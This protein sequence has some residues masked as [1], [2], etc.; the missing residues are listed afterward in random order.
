MANEMRRNAQPAAKFQPAP[1]RAARPSWVSNI[2]WTWL[3]WL[4]GFFI[5]PAAIRIITHFPVT[6]VISGY[7]G[8][9]DLGGQTQIFANRMLAFADF[10]GR[11]TI[12]IIMLVALLFILLYLI[13][14]K[15]ID[16]RKWGLS[17]ANILPGIVLFGLIWVSVYFL[18][19]PFASAF[20]GANFYLGIPMPP[21]TE[22]PIPY[23]TV[24][25]FGETLQ[26]MFMPKLAPM[27]AIGTKLTSPFET[28]IGL[29]LMD[30]IR[31]WFL[32]APVLLSMT[33]G[34]F[35]NSFKEKL[36]V[37]T[38]TSNWKK[39]GKILVTFFITVISVPIMQA[40]YRVVDEFLSHTADPTVA[41]AT[42]EAPKVTIMS[43]PS[44]FLVFIILAVITN[45]LGAS[46]QHR[47]RVADTFPRVFKWLIASVLAIVTVVIVFAGERFLAPVSYTILSGIFSILLVTS[48]SW[49]MF[50]NTADSTAF[51]FSETSKWASGFVVIIIGMLSMLIMKIINMADLVT[52]PLV[53]TVAF[54]FT[55]AVM[56]NYLVKWLYFDP[57]PDKLGDWGR[58]LIKWL[59][60]TVI[61]IVGL[62]LSMLNGW[63][64]APGM[65]GPFTNNFGLF[66]ML[67]LCAWI[68]VRT[69][70][71]IATFLLYASVPWFLNFIQVQA[72]Q[73]PT[74]AGSILTGVFVLAAILII[75][76][77]YKLWSHWLEF[78][79]EI[80]R[81]PIQE[82][83]LPETTPATGA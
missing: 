41:G 27:Y 44:F 75:V 45:I 59:P 58:S 8:L 73:V 29:G 56:G 13:F 18:Y 40:L 15:K 30:F 4:L 57:N 50:D 64:V 19:I 23:T 33:F 37:L 11:S 67:L 25:D 5:V 78:D 43:E 54:W 76:E 80:I 32:N 16:V 21:Q 24:A 51:G 48:I 82:E 17:V 49:L 62:G 2:D 6:W 53:L 46:S 77:S 70:N 36:G 28:N 66:T 68:Y 34:F 61:F 52:V 79:V 74:L 12:T 35:Y 63:H 69:E 26:I 83:A 81:K 55:C 9:G 47:E 60:G 1:R 72:F 20:S 22:M 14:A 31:V 39:Y 10:Y 3:Y 42:V 71:L 65:Y 7:W 38:A